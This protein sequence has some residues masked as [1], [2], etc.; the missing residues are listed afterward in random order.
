MAVHFAVKNNVDMTEGGFVYVLNPWDLMGALKAL[1][2]WKQTKKSWKEYRLA[3][4]KRGHECFEEWDEVYLPGNHF[5]KEKR[6]RDAAK[7]EIPELPLEPMVLEFPQITRRV[8]AQ[9]SRFMVYGSDKKWLIGWAE[10]R[11]APIWR[12]TIPK[13][14]V[15]SIKIQLRDAGI[16]ES[17]IFPDLDGLG[18]ELDQ[19]WDSLRGQATFKK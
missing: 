3:Q 4:M 2:S 9:R 17:V 15:A 12:I 7:A 13:S 6:N 19:L 5:L 14:S 18:R 16:T 11:N 10:K 1:P 8:A